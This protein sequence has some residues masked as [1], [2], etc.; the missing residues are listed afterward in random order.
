MLLNNKKIACDNNPNPKGYTFA[1][2]SSERCNVQFSQWYL[3]YGF[4]YHKK[5]VVL[6][7][8]YMI[9]VILLLVVGTLIFR[10]ATESRLVRREKE[11][12]QALYTAELG[13]EYGFSEARNTPMF[14]WLTHYVDAHTAEL[15]RLDHAVYPAIVDG[16]RVFLP[17]D[18]HAEFGE[19]DQDSGCYIPDNIPYGTIEVKAYADP[20][21]S[22][23]T[24]M[25]SRARV[26]SSE[27]IIKYKMAASSLFEN[28]FLY[29]GDHSFY[30]TDYDGKLD[31]DGNP[32]GKIYVDGNIKLINGT[33]SNI[34]ELSTNE[35]G[36]IHLY[37]RQFLAPYYLDDRDGVRDGK[38]PLP[39]L[40]A[41]TAHIFKIDDPYPWQNLRWPPNNFPATD[42]FNIDN[43][44]Y[45]QAGFFRWYRNPPQL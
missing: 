32:L 22:D 30:R 38:A 21:N 34:K 43:H 31:A 10:T 39:Q 27:K 13:I 8:S 12:I 18:D 26:D 45:S 6:I 4:L 42:W 1:I 5:G 19:I 15:I 28:F 33:F 14:Q 3:Q 40:G 36:K 2:P 23:E 24:W 44:F 35:L 37:S 11:T 7:A 41:E 17:F 29:P 16:E 25:L 9:T 20:N